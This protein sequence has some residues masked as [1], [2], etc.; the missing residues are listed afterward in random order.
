MSKTTDKEFSMSRVRNIWVNPEGRRFI[1]GFNGP[2][3]YLN[4]LNAMHEAVLTLD[5]IP[6]L[7]YLG[8]IYGIVDTR[9]AIGSEQGDDWKI[10]TVSAEQRAEA[11]L[12]TIGKWEDS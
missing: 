1:H 8:F 2:P 12:R 3:D 7:Q 9:G 11:F 5:G 4:D 10:H 6:R